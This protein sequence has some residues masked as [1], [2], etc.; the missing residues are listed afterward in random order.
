MNNFKILPL[1][2]DI[3]LPKRSNELAAGL[4]IFS[5]YSLTLYPKKPHLIPLGFKAELPNDYFCQ[6]M[7]RSSMCLRNIIVLG[8]VIDPDY[9][10]QYLL[11]FGVAFVQ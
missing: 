1:S 7:G 3:I 11:L 5:P 8:G 10:G 6:L 9:R 4:D 2:K